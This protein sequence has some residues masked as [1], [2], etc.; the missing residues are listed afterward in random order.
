MNV[1]VVVRDCP[2]FVPVTTTGK[3]PDAVKVHDKVA[4]WLGGRVTLTGIVQATLLDDNA[5]AP[6]NCGDR[7]PPTLIVAASG[8]PLTPLIG[9]LFERAKLVTVNENCVVG[10]RVTPPPEQL[11]LIV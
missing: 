7:E 6:L 9:P 10:A 2:V 11:T 8:L 1:T 5:T 3:E 4:V